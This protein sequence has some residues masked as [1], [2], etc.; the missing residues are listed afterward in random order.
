MAHYH[1]GIIH[2]RQGEY[3]AAAREFERSLEESSGDVSSL[4][5]LALVRDAQ[6]DHSAAEE[7]RRRARGFAK[8]QPVGAK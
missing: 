3:E 2:E 5:H 1:L 6:G 7:L 8:S 4:Y